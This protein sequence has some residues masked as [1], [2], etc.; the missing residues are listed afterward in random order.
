MKLR[1]GLLTRA[2]VPQENLASPHLAPE[3]SPIIRRCASAGSQRTTERLKKLSARMQHMYIEGGKCLNQTISWTF[4][5]KCVSPAIICLGAKSWT[6]E[7]SPKIFTQS[8]ASL[9]NMSGG[10]RW[11]GVEEAVVVGVK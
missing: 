7:A 8:K 2:T 3:D 9:K 5:S 11:E 1:E 4:S 10:R 6:N